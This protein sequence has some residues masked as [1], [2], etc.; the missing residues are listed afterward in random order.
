M[1]GVPNKL[2]SAAARPVAL[3]MRPDLVARSR[4]MAGSRWWCVKDPISQRF[5][6]LRD[7][8]YA[9][10][11]T[12]DGH[13]SLE[14]IRQQ[15]EQRFAPRRLT[16]DRLQTFLADMHRSGLLISANSG[17]GTQ[18]LERH[19]RKTH[20]RR[21]TAWTNILSIRFPGVDPDAF[22][23]WLYP[24]CR[25]LFSA[26]F[27]LA[28]ML[29]VA[30][31]AA[32]VA[33]QW[34]SLEARLPD[35]GA[36]VSAANLPWLV[37]VLA[38][39]KILHELAHA[40]AC[41]HFGGECHEI[42]LMLLIFTPCLYTNVSDS[43]LLPSRWHRAGVAAAGMYVELIL[44]SLCTFLWWYSAPGLLNMLAL[45][46]MI[47]C[48]ISTILFNG[49]PLLRYDGY[50]I[51]SDLVEVPNLA[52]ESRA[53][54]RRLL[55]RV[56]LGIT[57]NDHHVVPPRRRTFLVVYAVASILYRAV[58]IV[59]V[60][61]LLT[62]ALRPYRLEILAHMVGAVVIAGLVFTPLA[63]LVRF[64]GNPLKTDQVRRPRALFT[65][66][67][68]AAVLAAFFLV[69]LPFHVPAPAVLQYDG[70]QNV[71]V[72]VPGRLTKTIRAGSQVTLGQ[73]L[74]RLSSLDVDLQ[75]ARLTAERDGR[76]LQLTNLESRGA[77]DATAHVQIPAAREALTAAGRRLHQYQQDQQ[78]LVLSA[79]LA[80][81]VLPPPPIPPDARDAGRLT[82]WSD[83]PLAERNL[84][85]YLET[86]TLFCQVG[87]PTALEALLVIDQRDLEFVRPGD[88]VRIL[89]AHAPATIL[90]GRI[91]EISEIDLAVA[92][93]QLIALGDLPTR[94]DRDGVPRPLETP[95]QV[96][97]TLDDHDIPLVALTRCRAKIVAAPQSLGQRLIRY[98]A[99]TFRLEI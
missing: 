92:P 44:A 38:I 60:L 94:T 8:E 67:A 62:I 48:S 59:A 91:S 85:S 26:W 96:R 21:A 5:F 36:L 89:P 20:K 75:L 27:F 34:G 81:T 49:N 41:K 87:D 78:K 24:K 68:T 56:C 80:G 22:L 79:P 99:S 42:G 19:K 18:L 58:V 23:D 52:S 73:T 1:S 90:E 30:S 39:T 72:S 70:A 13:T 17:Q 74:A 12:L 32:L 63:D 7:E 93:R 88:R 97:V 10:L 15:F 28:S 16:N 86:G 65:A 35:V 77:L 3:E 57:Y 53:V 29:L 55:A 25:W 14:Q 31:A 54:L 64:L 71:Y 9:I 69:P 33:V 4:T 83:T 46:T 45:N 40:L 98:L 95:Y 2:T 11:Q 50:Y 43:W 84:G 82:T 6:H 51:L 61:W 47:V 37:L 66:T 76:R